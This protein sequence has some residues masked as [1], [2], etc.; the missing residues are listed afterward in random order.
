MGFE[1]GDKVLNLPQIMDSRYLSRARTPFQNPERRNPEERKIIEKIACRG[2]LH[3]NLE[4]WKLKE[5]KQADLLRKL[6]GINP[7]F[8]ALTNVV[9]TTETT[10]VAS[11]PHTQSQL[12]P[13]PRAIRF[14]EYNIDT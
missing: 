14:L 13:L 6:T 7:L 12:L 8:R 10:E 5:K 3:W 2:E 9:S 1:M 11:L 4:F